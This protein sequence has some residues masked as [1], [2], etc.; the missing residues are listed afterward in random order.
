MSVFYCECLCTVCY[1]SKYKGSSSKSLIWT[2]PLEL[3]GFVSYCDMPL[4][5]ASESHL[6]WLVC[7]MCIT[8]VNVTYFLSILHYYLIVSLERYFFSKMK[9]YWM[10]SFTLNKKWKQYWCLCDQV[11]GFVSTSNNVFIVVYSIVFY[12][13]F[14]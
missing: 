6:C 12:Y 7:T 8:I 10:V 4:W 14:L 9:N 11:V 1:A 13:L 3:Q 2:K 5:E